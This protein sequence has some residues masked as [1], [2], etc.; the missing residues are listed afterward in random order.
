M[1][2]RNNICFDKKRIFRVSRITSIITCKTFRLHALENMLILLFSFQFIFYRIMCL[3]NI[4]IINIIILLNIV[5][6]SVQRFTT[7]DKN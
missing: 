6:K 3:H 7:T 2:F 1:S 4:P 5:F